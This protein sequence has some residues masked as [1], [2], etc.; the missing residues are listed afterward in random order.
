[1]KKM[2]RRSAVFAALCAMLLPAMPAQAAPQVFFEDTQITRLSKNTYLFEITRIT[3]VGLVDINLLRI[4]LNE[5][6]LEVGVFNSQVQYGLKQPATT[7]LAQ[8][9]ALAGVNGDFFGLAGRHSVPLG[10]EVVDGHFSVHRGLNYENNTSASFLMGENGVF[11]DYIRAE[12]ALLLDGERPFE[13]SSMN[14]VS[15]LMFPSFLTY[16]YV[17]N[18]AEIDVRFPR[19]YKL[20]VENSIITNITHESVYVPQ[21]GFVVIMNDITFRYNN[22]LFQ[23]GQYAQMEFFTTIDEYA[24]HTAIS[25][26]RR[27]LHYG[28]IPDI[29]ATRATG[30]NPRTI[31]GICRHGETLFLMT[32]DGRN[33][34]V[35]ATLA[36]AARYIRDFGAYHAITLDG[37]G[38]TTM[39]AMR[40]GQNA[41]SLINTPSEGTQR[42]IIN[43]IGVINRTQLS[44]IT[45]L[46]IRLDQGFGARG[47]MPV[48]MPTNIKIIGFDAYMNSVSIPL[49]N[50][51]ISVFNADLTAYGI[52]PHA[53][54]N[55]Y[56]VVDFAGASRVS[57]FEAIE[58]AEIQP[59]FIGMDNLGR[60]VPL[61]PAFLE[62]YTH[63][64]HNGIG[65]WQRVSLGDVHLFMPIHASNAVGM[66]INHQSFASYPA[67]VRGSFE[68]FP[69]GVYHLNYAFDR[70]NFS[71][72][73]MVNL[74]GEYVQYAEYISFEVYGNN[75]NHWL[76]GH[77]IDETGNVFVL[78]FV[79]HIDFVGWRQV[80]VPVPQEAVGG[81]RLSRIWAVSLNQDEPHE[82]S[83]YFRLMHFL[84]PSIM[85]EIGLPASSRAAD[86]LRAN[87]SV[88][89]NLGDLGIIFVG[90]HAPSGEV[91]GFDIIHINAENGGILGTDASGWQ[92][93]VERLQMAQSGNIIIHTNFDLSRGNNWR[94]VEMLHQLLA[95]HAAY[96]NVFAVSHGG[97]SPYTARLLD[98]VRYVHL[99]AIYSENAAILRMRVSEIGLQY[100]I[101]RIAN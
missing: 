11:T 15:N 62:F 10:L 65:G 35:G 28:E 78:D 101:E 85:D 93:L 54:G 83:L 12:I 82:S 2:L 84:R 18:T 96:A 73:A 17:A 91:L 94:E 77:L 58:I 33:H 52:F 34:S 81:V 74:D 99:P 50:A 39:A 51:N 46:D 47:M 6:F 90:E 53:Q 80:V 7:L 92:Y 8:A 48:G 72:A 60:R 13:V 97:N 95:S 19:T 5:P 79:G 98:G 89:P 31:L 3:E 68:V 40:P 87:L 86:P 57:V 36:E 42:N 21:N 25:G 75:S 49:E 100:S 22:H 27:I 66:A 1:M 76:R 56:V 55:V 24:V 44:E 38:S 14:M 23:V 4:P 59:H 32:I 61:N 64:N 20:V 45:S 29:A 16:G 71:Q 70:G 37:G 26:E 88:P 43:T 30:R 69:D 41:L 67:N 9:G 63:I